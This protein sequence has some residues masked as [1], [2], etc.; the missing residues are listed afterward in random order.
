MG[1][2]KGS[3][4]YA[5]QPQVIRTVALLERLNLPTRVSI[6]RDQS[7]LSSY[8]G[9]DLIPDDGT[10]EGPA[11]GLVSAWNVEPGAAFLVLAVDMPFVNE[12]LIRQLLANRDPS[13]LAT[14]FVH[15]DG[16][17]EPLCTIY[18][19]GAEGPLRVRSEK[20]SPSLRR[21]LE[22]ADVALVQPADAGWLR[23]IDTRAS[24][25]RVRPSFDG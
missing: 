5:G 24:Y 2:D 6:R 15:A 19:P 14:A 10:I 1:H 25:E 22:S 12:A 16:T 3:L 4:E 17:I 23:S 9:L 20:G 18:E 8:D 11:A 21:L 13:K 7:S